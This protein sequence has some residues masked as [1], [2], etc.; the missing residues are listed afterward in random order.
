MWTSLKRAGDHF[1]DEVSLVFERDRPL[2]AIFRLNQKMTRE[3]RTFVAQYIKAYA[4]ASGW[5]V[6][7]IQWKNGHMFLMASSSEESSASKNFLT[8]PST[9]ND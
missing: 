4:A 7:R 1:G 2:E 8:S 6:R 9:S 3:M 5:E